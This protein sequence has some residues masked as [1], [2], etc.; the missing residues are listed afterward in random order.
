VASAATDVELLDRLRDGDETAFVELVT[1][2]QPRMLRLARNFVPSQ[3]VAEEVVQ[4]TW[5][6]V[7]RG[8]ERFEGRSSLATWLFAILVNRAKTAG[9]RE[10]R[11]QTLSPDELADPANRFDASGAWAAPPESWSDAADDRIVAAQFAA[12]ARE[13]L[14]ALPA[15]QR[16]VVLLRDVEG[17]TSREVCDVLGITEGNQRVLLH[18]GRSRVRT[19]LEP[20]VTQR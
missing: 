19:A 9:V 12:R 4:D 15:A 17:L 3:A 8:I 1:V 5:L 6:A 16:E 20:E 2:Y 14:D 7:V 13:H 18:R 11:D 10:N